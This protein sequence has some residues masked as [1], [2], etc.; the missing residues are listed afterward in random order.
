MRVFL[1]RL[2]FYALAPL[3][4]ADAALTEVLYAQQ[5]LRVIGIGLLTNHEGLHMGDLLLRPFF[6][7]LGGSGSSEKVIFIQPTTADC[8]PSASLHD[9]DISIHTAQ[10][11]S[12]AVPQVYV[13]PI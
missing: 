11:N 1:E 10:A 12:T 4:Y 2:S 9:Y 8:D 5:E 6:P 7:G 13:W 3:P